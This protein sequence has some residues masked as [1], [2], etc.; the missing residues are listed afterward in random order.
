[1]E[2]IHYI[3]IFHIFLVVSYSG[4]LFY[5]L[6]QFLPNFLDVV[7]PRNESRLHYIPLAAEY[8]VDQQEYYLPILLHIDIIALIGFA[9]VISTESLMT[10]FI[11]HTVGM[12]EIAR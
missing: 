2:F 7:S 10:A 9:T 1:M 5:L 3:F 8:F 6:I 11:R 12:F 4:L